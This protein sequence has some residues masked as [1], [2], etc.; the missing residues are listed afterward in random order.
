MLSL[1]L[2]TIIEA[3]LAG[4][5]ILGCRSMGY[6]IIRS[7]WPGVRATG[8]EYKNGASLLTGA[9]L[10]AGTGIIFAIPLA[11]PNFVAG[12]GGFELLAV[13]AALASGSGIVLLTA[14]RKFGASRKARVSVPK[15]IVTA[16]IVSKMAVGML[17]EKFYTKSAGEEQQGLPSA[18]PA[19]SAGAG[20][21]SAAAYAGGAFEESSEGGLTFV[22]ASRQKKGEKAIREEY[23][24]KPTSETA[25][26]EQRVSELKR[27]LID[28]SQGEAPQARGAVFQQAWRGDESSA[29]QRPA[30][31]EAV[32][33]PTKEIIEKI[34]EKQKSSSAQG[35]VRGLD[36]NKQAP[37]QAVQPA[38]PGQEISPAKPQAQKIS[39]EQKKGIFSSIFGAQKPSLSAQPAK[40]A[41]AAAPAP[42]VQIP[43]AKQS[44]AQAAPPL[45]SPKISVQSKF[46]QKQLPAP[47][48][49]DAK[50]AKAAE[51]YPAPLPAQP[52]P[53]HE[54]AQSYASPEP[55]IVTGQPSAQKIADLRKRL[56]ELDTSRPLGEQLGASMGVGTKSAIGSLRRGIPAGMDSQLR[57]R[58]REQEK[59]SEQI[60]GL[61]GKEKERRSQSVT[62]R[63]KSGEELRDSLSFIREE[64]RE[65]LGLERPEGADASRAPQDAM[66]KSARLLK[67]LLKEG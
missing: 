23:T 16:G 55:F 43:F 53:E 30:G 10:L 52:A 35:S 60:I 61:L 63:E 50:Q 29:G 6:I 33:E 58:E 39:G 12:V 26:S 5:V 34:V 24:T 56:S 14:K 7:G 28:K 67:E 11:L 19:F 45:A 15:R 32:F 38:K 22:S 62:T 8:A 21:G 37:A 46:A 64:L 65:R 57:A 36:M 17:P 13:S 4:Y 40:A 20:P 54:A 31:G 27:R 9:G 41:P 18:P 47:Q 42:P 51:K 2:T 48:H 25:A 3:G 44:S 49:A 66:P 1:P 59:N